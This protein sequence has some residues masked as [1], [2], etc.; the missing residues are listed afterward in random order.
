MINLPDGPLTDE[1]VMYLL[2]RI[3]VEASLTDAVALLIGQALAQ[4]EAEAK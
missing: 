3:L 2:D 4:M 1:D